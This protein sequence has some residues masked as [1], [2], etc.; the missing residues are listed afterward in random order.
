VSRYVA[1]GCRT[2]ILDVPESEEELA[3]TAIVFQRA[4]QRSTL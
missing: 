4:R 1:A 3:H 2:F